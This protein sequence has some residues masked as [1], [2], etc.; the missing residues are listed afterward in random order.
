[1]RGG[2]K[3]VVVAGGGGGG[4]W[5]AAAGASRREDGEGAIGEEEKW[6]LGSGKDTGVGIGQ[7][8]PASFS[9]KRPR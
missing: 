1:V 4:A 6:G 7:I 8:P 9:W 5:V 2:E 3:R